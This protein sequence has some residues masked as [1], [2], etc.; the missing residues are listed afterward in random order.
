M[1]INAPPIEF[2]GLEE[3]SPWA[4]GGHSLLDFEGYIKVKVG[5]ATPEQGKKDPSKW[6]AKVSIVCL[7]DDCMG[8]PLISRPI[9]KGLDKNG[10][11]LNRQFA[12]FLMSIG[13]DIEKIHDNAKK[14]AKGDAHAT[15][16]GLKDREGYVEVKWGSYEGKTTT[17]VANWISQEVYV[18]A[19]AVGGTRRRRRNPDGS[20]PGQQAAAPVDANAMGGNSASATT[21]DTMGPT[22]AGADPVPAL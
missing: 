6:H 20:F 13:T 7:D 11:S 4:G 15:L 3:Y 10:K 22:T 9:Y 8:M 5:E 16:A 17:E 1:V 12:D 2:E 18:K 21:V 14:K 19:A